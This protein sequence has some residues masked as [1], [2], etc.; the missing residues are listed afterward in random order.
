MRLAPG[1]DPRHASA[2]ESA[3]RRW[4]DVIVAGVPDEYLSI[5]GGVFA[6][7]PAYDGVVDDLLIDAQ[8][9]PIDGRGR[10]LGQAGAVAARA[11]TEFRSTGS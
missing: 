8:S 9:E 7:I 2:F 4:E 11:E 5:P 6:W 1:M 3:A 10:V